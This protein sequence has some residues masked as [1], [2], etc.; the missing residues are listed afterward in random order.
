MSGTASTRLGRGHDVARCP[1]RVVRLV[2]GDHLGPR[3]ERDPA[4][5]TA[6]AGHQLVHRLARVLDDDIDSLL[7]EAH[8]LA[9][10]RDL[11]DAGD[12]DRV[13]VTTATTA[14]TAVV[15]SDELAD[16]DRRDDE[17]HGPDQGKHPLHGLTVAVAAVSQSPGTN[18]TRGN[19]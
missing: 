17:G 3:R 18:R 1:E 7:A 8:A 9:G 19:T 16:G 10:R 15:T 6:V 14:A 2:D 4:V 13:A 11:G 5:V 12:D